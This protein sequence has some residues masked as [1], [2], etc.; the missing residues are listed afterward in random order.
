MEIVECPGHL[1]F[2]V[3]ADTPIKHGVVVVQKPWRNKEKKNTIHIPQEIFM[4]EGW[5]KC[6]DYLLTKKTGALET[7]LQVSENMHISVRAQAGFRRLA[8]EKKF[9]NGKSVP[10]SYIMLTLQGA[11]F[12]MLKSSTLIK[13]KEDPSNKH[14]WAMLA[15]NFEKAFDAAN[16]GEKKVYIQELLEFKHST[17]PHRRTMELGF[18][19]L[20]TSL[21]VILNETFD[22]LYPFLRKDIFRWGATTF[23]VKHVFTVPGR[24]QDVVKRKEGEELES[25]LM[26]FDWFEKLEAEMEE[27]YTEKPKAKKTTTKKKKKVVVE[28]ETSPVEEDQE[29]DQEMNTATASSSSPP[30]EVSAEKESEEE[31]EKDENPRTANNKFYGIDID[32]YPTDEASSDEEISEASEKKLR[33]AT[34]QEIFDLE[35]GQ[36]AQSLL[37]V[38]SLTDYKKNVYMKKKQKRNLAKRAS[39]PTEKPFKGLDFSDDDEDEEVIPPNQLASP[40]Y[41]PQDRHM[42]TSALNNSTPKK[43]SF[44]GF[45][46]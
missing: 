11:F 7:S 44:M 35:E 10:G 16:F 21:K 15:I 42:K 32:D 8:I 25:A 38:D 31:E 9:P 14:V 36:N 30:E 19:D 13:N 20:K 24:G 17:I 1:G 28:K 33:M 37:S 46:D 2:T 26:F 12:L 45:K 34:E 4:H 29:V 41:Y 3:S 22:W 40:L 43:R 23:D 5:F 18:L 27:K 6:L 39:A